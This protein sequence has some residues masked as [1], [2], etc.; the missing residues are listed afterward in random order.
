[1][2]ITV[3]VEQVIDTRKTKSNHMKEETKLK[4]LV[5]TKR[6]NEYNRKMCN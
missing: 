6:F 2:V 4:F 3:Q 1:M 5:M